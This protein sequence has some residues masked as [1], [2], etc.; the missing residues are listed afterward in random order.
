MAELV[1]S[2]FT[3]QIRFHKERVKKIET[4]IDNTKQLAYD[5]DSQDDESN[6]WQAMLQNLVKTVRE[7]MMDKACAERHIQALEEVQQKVANEQDIEI[8]MP[9]LIREKLVYFS[10]AATDEEIVERS[11]A[12]Q[13]FLREVGLL[14]APAQNAPPNEG[15]DS[16]EELTVVVETQTIC[17]ITQSD[18]VVPMKNKNCPHSY[19]QH[20]IYQT[21]EAA[22]RT[23]IPCPVAGCSKQVSKSS[24]VVNRELARFVKKK[25]KERSQQ[26]RV[27]EYT[28]L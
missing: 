9:S 24:L 1:L 16:D 17:P 26:Q 28:Q 15:E 6:D 19:S 10:S 3:D 21:I 2:A 27:Q 18:F 7:L 4:A 13:Q 12:Y 11:Q 5:I 23:S 25:Q 14:E 20:A 22:R 8:D